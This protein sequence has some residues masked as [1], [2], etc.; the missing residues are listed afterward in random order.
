M[1]EICFYGIS[2]LL[3]SGC[4]GSGVSTTK[5]NEWVVNPKHGLVQ[6]LKTPD[7]K[8]K[9]NYRTPELVAVQNMGIEVLNDN[10]VMKDYSEGIYFTMQMEAT[11][12]KSPEKKIEE[13]YD[14]DSSKIVKQYLMFNMRDNTTM[15]LGQD[16]L[17]CSFFDFIQTGNIQDQYQFFIGFKGV[18]SIGESDLTVCFKDKVLH[19]SDYQIKFK[20]KDIKNIPNIKI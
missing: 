20:N 17:P 15:I 6:E 10:D 18:K 12:G 11:D 9:W 3:L 13:I 1:L 19:G 7:W 2:L 4:I 16:T 14:K 5:Q 8:F